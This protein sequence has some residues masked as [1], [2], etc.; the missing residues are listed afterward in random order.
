MSGMMIGQRVVF[1]EKECVILRAYG[2][3]VYMV[4]S[5][6]DGKNSWFTD[7]VT[8]D[9][10]IGINQIGRDEILFAFH[11]TCE[12]PT[13]EQIDEWAGRYP[14]LAEDIR[15]HAA[16]ARDAYAYKEKNRKEGELFK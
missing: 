4:G 14:Q 16:I 2:S 10:L 12:C 11:Q 15:S 8:E 1:E 3:G 9:E 13:E 6:H 7:L 5:E